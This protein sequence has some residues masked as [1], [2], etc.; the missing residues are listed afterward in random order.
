MIGTVYVKL[1]NDEQLKVHSNQLICSCWSLYF[2]PP[3]IQSPFVMCIIRA[4]LS[5][6]LKRVEKCHFFIKIEKKVV[7]CSY[8][9]VLRVPKTIP[10]SEVSR[11][12]YYVE[13]SN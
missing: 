6:L 1:S 8:G 5:Q 12:V 3:A 7:I 4:R 11:L 9:I 13:P 2:F 10:V